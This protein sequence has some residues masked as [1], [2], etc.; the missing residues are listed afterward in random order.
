MPGRT[1]LLSIRP[2]FADK[3]FAGTKTVELRRIRPKVAIQDLVLVYASTP[4]RAIVGA[5]R[6]REVIEKSPA[7]LW[8]E[9]RDH[10]GI[11]RRQFDDY[12]SGAPK[13]FGIFLSSV[14]RF[15][16]PVELIRLRKLWPG[17]HPPQS[18]RYLDLYQA[19]LILPYKSKITRL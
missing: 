14:R 18:Y 8:K 2:E 1:L 15:H 12:Y 6:V 3:V 10:A 16:Q 17:F 4:V 7:M 13:A 19:R 9:V 11:T 5:F